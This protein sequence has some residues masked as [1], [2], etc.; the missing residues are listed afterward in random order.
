MANAVRAFVLLPHDDYRHAHFFQHGVVQ[1]REYRGEED[2]AV[3]AVAAK[4]LQVLHL[5]FGVVGG[6]DEQKLV[7]LLAQHLAYPL[8]LARAALAGKPRY[9]HADE[10]C[11]FGAHV[12]RLNAWRVARSLYCGL[13]EPAF[14]LAHIAVVKISAYGG[15]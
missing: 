8:D 14:F 4:K 11:H 5:F 7:A 6:V 12:L 2:N 1:R 9:Y 10:L 3:N 13:D 15:F